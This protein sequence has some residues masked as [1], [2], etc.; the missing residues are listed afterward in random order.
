MFER[1]PLMLGAFGLA[2]GAAIAASLPLSDV[3][4]DLMGDTADV[5]KGK[6]GRLFEDTKGRAA[7]LAS[8]GL[9]EAELQGLTPGAASE[10]ARN[11]TTRVAGLVQK[12]SADVVDR[13]KR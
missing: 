10:A 12:V 2:V 3:E 6:A 11:V 13:T 4:N 5:V 9:K 1:Q 7:D 8:K